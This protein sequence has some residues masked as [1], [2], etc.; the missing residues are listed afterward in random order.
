MKKNHYFSGS[1]A[2]FRINRKNCTFAPKG[3]I[4]SSLKCIMMKLKELGMKIFNITYIGAF[5]FRYIRN[6]LKMNT[7]W[8]LYENNEFSKIQIK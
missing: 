4:A 6:T 5:C 2:K 7:L 3:R 1:S 8:I